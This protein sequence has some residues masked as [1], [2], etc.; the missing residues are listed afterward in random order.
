[1]AVFLGW[2]ILHEKVDRFVLTGTVIIIA[3]VVLVTTS[4]LKRTDAPAL[5][6]A[7]AEIPAVEQGA[8]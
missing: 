3:S 5:Q 1:M 4:K 8:D 2:L 6:T 7:E